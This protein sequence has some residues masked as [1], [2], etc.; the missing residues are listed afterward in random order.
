MFTP[1]EVCKLADSHEAESIALVSHE[2]GCKEC[3]ADQIFKHEEVSMHDLNSNYTEGTNRSPGEWERASLSQPVAIS[4]PR[5]LGKTKPA[6]IFQP[7]GRIAGPIL[8][9]LIDSTWLVRSL[10]AGHCHPRSSIPNLPTA[11]VQL[12]EDLRERTSRNLARQARS[13]GVR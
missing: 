5:V 6:T 13:A 4:L 7:S 9:E 1:H 11:E 12:T 10:Q 2:Q 8:K 3:A